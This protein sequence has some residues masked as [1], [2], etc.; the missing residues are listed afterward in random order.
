MGH[1]LRP[2]TEQGIPVAEVSTGII[3]VQEEFANGK[4]SGAVETMMAQLQS[5]NIEDK[6]RQPSTFS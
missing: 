4:E 3:V 6:V 5:V 1:C 2:A